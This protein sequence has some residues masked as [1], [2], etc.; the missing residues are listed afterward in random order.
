M[1]PIENR[2]VRGVPSERYP[3]NPISS[4]PDSTEKVDDPHHI[5]PRSEIIGDSWF[6]QIMDLETDAVSDPIPHVTGLSRSE[7]DDVEQHRAWIKLEDGVF[8]WYQRQQLEGPEYTF[9]LLGPL[10]PQPGQVGTP[11]KKKR[12]FQGE[13]KRKRSNWQVKIPADS[14]DGAGILDD[15]F[16]RAYEVV[17]DEGN[18]DAFEDRTQYVC[19]ADIF[20]W[21]GQNATTAYQLEQA[22]ERLH[23]LTNG[24]E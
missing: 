15:G 6:V 19:L 11:K 3:L 23:E 2:N 9:E 14:E 5:F 13:A 24:D 7:H 20:E 12:A 16:R 17:A 1:K 21:V 4:K 18:L 8:N 10:N 22:Q